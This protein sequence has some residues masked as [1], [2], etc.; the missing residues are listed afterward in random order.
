MEN[1]PASPIVDL[2]ESGAEFYPQ[3]VDSLPTADGCAHIP[4]ASS[5]T[6]PAP[7]SGRI[8]L[9][10]LSS[11]QLAQYT[12]LSTWQSLFSFAQTLGILIAGLSLGFIGFSM[13]SLSPLWG[14]VWILL[15]CFI[16]ACGQHGLAIL[17][18]EGTHYRLFPSRAMNDEIGRI[19][20]MLIGVSTFSYR[21]VHRLHHNHLYQDQDP[22]LPLMAGY[23][24]GRAYLMRKL[25]KDCAGLTAWRNYAYFFGAPAQSIKSDKTSN[26]ILDNTHPHLRRQALR[27]RWIVLGF[28]LGLLGVMTLVGWLI[29]YLLLWVLPAVTIQAVFLR[30]RAVL[31][32]GA[33]SDKTQVLQC[34]RTNT[35]LSW[36]LKMTLFPHHVNYHLEH[37]LYPAVPHYHL[38]RLHEHLRRLGVLEGTEVRP[39][40]EALQ[41]IFSDPIPQPTLHTPLSPIKVS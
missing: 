41:R 8:A 10:F 32:H 6:L 13:L 30:L 20:G 14:L 25:L 36:W 17:S 19:C 35:H 26:T 16:T 11:E 15:G 5:S 23:P 34:A 29:P 37:H 21:I 31:E 18:H 9:H 12:R 2:I 24:R 3:A 38:P 39:L 4:N 1:H 33:P 7:A 28:Q 27:D 40:K 22:D